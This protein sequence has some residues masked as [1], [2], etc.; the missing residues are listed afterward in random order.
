MKI[1]ITNGVITRA[2]PQGIYESFYKGS[3]NWRKV[4]D[5]N[6]EKE[7]RGVL[8]TRSDEKNPRETTL[9]SDYEEISLDEIPLSEMTGHQLKEYAAFHNIDISG[10]KTKREVI[11][12][13]N[14]IRG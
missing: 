1:K 8:F 7:R 6:D 10:L 3:N 11:Q 2:V 12:R 4:D 9:D 14:E 5:L 13:I